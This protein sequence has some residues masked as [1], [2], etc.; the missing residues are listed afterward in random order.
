MPFKS[1]GH[2][3]LDPVGLFLHQDKNT[4]GVIVQ[5]SDSDPG[6]SWNSHQFRGVVGHHRIDITFWHFA[7]AFFLSATGADADQRQGHQPD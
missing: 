6:H 5:L 4:R 3:P 2:R 7:P 1:P